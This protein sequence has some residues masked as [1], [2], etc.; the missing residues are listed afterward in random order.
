MK[1][2]MMVMTDGRGEYLTQTIKSAEINI[3]GPVAQVVIVNDSGDPEY[4]AWLDSE[5]P[6][7]IK[8]HHRER[9]G[10]GEAIQ[11]GWDYLRSNINPDWVFHLEDDFTFNRPVPLIDM[12]ATLAGY[13]HL[14]QM[15]LRRQPVNDIE[16]IAGGVIEQWPNEY[17]EFVDTAGAWLEHTLFF[18]TNPSLYKMSLAEVGWPTGRESERAFTIRL[19]KKGYSGTPGKKVRF[20]FWGSRLDQPWV[21]H[22]GEQRVGTGY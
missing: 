10:F 8:H 6:K 11:S 17:Q 13:P 4:A 3:K 14:A 15:A 22:I 20:G 18:T 19:L 2:A 16:R 1:I 7:Y 5:F 9:L 12:V 21:H